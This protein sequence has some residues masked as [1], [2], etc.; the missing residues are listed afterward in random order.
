MRTEV[1]NIAIT[2]V[3]V[4]RTLKFGLCVPDYLRNWLQ[5]ALQHLLGYIHHF[6][7]PIA[8]QVIKQH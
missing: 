7:T 6:E 4:Y 2:S 1:L 3:N 8:L 5:N